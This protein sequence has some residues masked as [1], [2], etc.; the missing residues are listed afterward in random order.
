MDTLLIVSGAVLLV[1]GFRF[2]P[3]MQDVNAARWLTAAAFLIGGVLIQVGHMWM[4][5]AEGAYYRSLALLIPLCIGLAPCMLLPGVVE[6]LRAPG[7]IL[8]A[9]DGT[10]VRPKRPATILITLWVLLFTAAG[11]GQLVWILFDA[12][13]VIDLCT[14]LLTPLGM[15]P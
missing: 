12:P 2:A 14:R 8:A 9:P 3:R 5:A 4:L 13:A 1:L 7:Q 11:I 15:T 6:R 10:P